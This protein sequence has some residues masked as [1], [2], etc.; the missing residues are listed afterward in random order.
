[1][2]DPSKRVEYIGDDNFTLIL[3][4]YKKRIL[5]KHNDE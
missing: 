3:H 4:D 1:M 5:H 2:L